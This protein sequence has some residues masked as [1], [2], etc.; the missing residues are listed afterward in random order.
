MRK[1]VDELRPDDRDGHPRP[2]R[3]GATPTACVFLADGQIVDEMLAPDGRRR[4][5]QDEEPRAA[6]SAMW[7]VTLK[8][9]LAHKVRFLLTGVAVMLGVAFVSGTFVLTATISATRST[10]SSTTSTSTPTRSCG[11][12]RSSAVRAS[13]TRAAARSVPTLLPTVRR[14][15]RRRRGRRDGAGTRGHRRQEGRRARQQRSGRAHARL[16][17]HPRP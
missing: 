12:R 1:A 7:K 5:R 16:Q 11:P 6:T 4:A 13:A 2:D 17:L 15:R 8:G 9:I 14:R 10:S 3:R